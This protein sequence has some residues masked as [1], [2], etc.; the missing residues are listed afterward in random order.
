MIYTFTDTVRH[1]SSKE[2]LQD[3]SNKHNL[4]HLKIIPKNLTTIKTIGVDQW[5][6]E[7]AR[8]WK[9]PDCQTDFSL[10]TPKCKK[11]GRDLDKI[12]DYNNL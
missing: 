5:L 10:Y 9:C 4:P 3:F 2:L 7:Q 1:Y 6:K 8:I 11:C 12:K